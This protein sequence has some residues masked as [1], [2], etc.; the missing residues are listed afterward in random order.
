MYKMI[1]AVGVLCIFATQVTHAATYYGNTVTAGSASARVYVIENGS[2]AVEVGIEANATAFVNLASDIHLH[3]ELPANG[4]FDV[5]PIDHVDIGFAVGGHP[6][7]PW[8]DEAGVPENSYWAVPHFDVHFMTISDADANSI[9]IPDPADVN[10][11]A[12]VYPEASE[13]AAGYALGPNSGV[14]GEGSHWAANSEFSDFPAPFDYNFL[15]GFYDGSMTFEEPMVAQTFLADLKNGLTS[16]VLQ[17]FSVSSTNPAFGNQ[18]FIRYNAGNDVF[19][20]GVA[21]IPEPSTFILVGLG[22]LGFG[23]CRRSMRDL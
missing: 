3:L 5:S 11:P 15:Y 19:R 14:G 6:G 16:D 20:I 22:F 23:L 10:D 13:L 17:T 2:G 8:S 7:G 21:T 4:S 12:Y 1:V 9:A 18:Y